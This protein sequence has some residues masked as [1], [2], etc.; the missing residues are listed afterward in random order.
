MTSN[1]IIYRNIVLKKP[2]H[3]NNLDDAAAN[4]KHVQKRD[5]QISKAAKI[6]FNVHVTQPTTC[7]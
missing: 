1:T 5:S 6:S 7:L 2:K 4:G 3:T